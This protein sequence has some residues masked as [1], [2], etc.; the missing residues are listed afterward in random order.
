VELSPEI[1]EFYNEGTEITRLAQGLG[2]LE[3]ARLQEIL[4][5]YLAPAPALVADIGGGPGIYAS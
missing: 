3:L 4:P 2:R 5:R 1:A